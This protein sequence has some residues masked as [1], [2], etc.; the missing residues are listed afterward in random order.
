[1]TIRF[2]SSFVLGSERS[3]RDSTYFAVYTFVSTTMYTNYCT[4][5]GRILTILENDGSDRY[6]LTNSKVKL[7]KSVWER[8]CWTFESCRQELATERLKLRMMQ[9]GFEMFKLL[10]KPIVA[11]KS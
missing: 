5:G 2:P 9:C 3:S 10:P 11:L 8:I 4:Y 1:M 7:S 6:K